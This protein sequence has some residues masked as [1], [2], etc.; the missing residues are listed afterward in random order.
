MSLTI[1]G[2]L[3][4][5]VWAK[6]AGF[7][8]KNGD[9]ALRQTYPGVG[10]YRAG[11]FQPEVNGGLAAILDPANTIVKMFF[12]GDFLYLGF[13]A[14]DQ[15]V[16][17]HTSFDRWDGFIVTLNDRVL[18][19]P[20]KNLLSRRLSFQVGPTG[21]AMPQDSLIR[22]VNNGWAQVATALRAGTTV[23][24]LGQQ[25]DNGYTAEGIDLT[26]FSTHPA[27]RRTLFGASIIWTATRSFPITDSYGHARGGSVNARRVLSGRAHGSVAAGLVAR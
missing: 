16:Q 2:L 3:N 6:Q 21:Q 19:G 24:T 8:I 7:R 27:R 25:A 26:K 9:A 11:Q 5:P 15:I 1:D 23:D 20:D 10:P 13:E 22:F 17:Y 18:R 14:F 4:D 12:K